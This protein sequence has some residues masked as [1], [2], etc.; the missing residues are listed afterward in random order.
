MK[1]S[2][3]VESASAVNGHWLEKDPEREH[4]VEPDTGDN[5]AHADDDSAVG[6]FHRYAT[7]RVGDDSPPKTAA[8][9]PAN[10]AKVVGRTPNASWVA[11]YTLASGHLRRSAACSSSASA[12]SGD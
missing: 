11:R 12:K 2:V 6:V 5:H 10:S 8:C 3:P 9:R 7:P 1:R 4:C